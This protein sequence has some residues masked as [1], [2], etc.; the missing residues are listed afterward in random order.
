[1]NSQLPRDEHHWQIVKDNN[2]ENST[3]LQ[4]Q[5]VLFNKS[6]KAVITNDQRAKCGRELEDDPVA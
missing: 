5:W 1:V 2:P 4:Q 6:G 3:F